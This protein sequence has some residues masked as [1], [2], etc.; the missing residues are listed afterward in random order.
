MATENVSQRTKGE[1]RSGS[2]FEEEPTQSAVVFYPSLPAQ[3]W[4]SARTVLETSVGWER[5]VK[6]DAAAGAVRPKRIVEQSWFRHADICAYSMCFTRAHGGDKKEVCC[7][8]HGGVGGSGELSHQ[9]KGHRLVSENSLA[10]DKDHQIYTQTLK[11]CIVGNI[12]SFQ[13]LKSSLHSR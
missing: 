4:W 12:Q 2:R 11:K 10:E 9:C 1:K 5:E 3:A 13:I 8:M 6:D 7:I